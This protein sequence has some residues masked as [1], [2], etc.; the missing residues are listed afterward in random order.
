MNKV[1]A[2]IERVA[3][4]TY[5][6]YIDLEDD[7]LNYGI[8]G[9]GDTVEEAIEDFKLSYTDMKALY[10]EEGKEFQETTFEF[11]YDLPSF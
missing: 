5:S 1:K 7:T 3:D 11:L 4:G 10:K 2:F 6:V 9:E 8:I